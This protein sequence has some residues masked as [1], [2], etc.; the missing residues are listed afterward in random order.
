MEQKRR[1]EYEDQRRKEEE[2]NNDQMQM[3]LNRL[4]KLENSRSNSN[5][6]EDIR[7]EGLSEQNFNR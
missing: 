6:N 4:N 2:G 1:E 7:M 5:D 3:L